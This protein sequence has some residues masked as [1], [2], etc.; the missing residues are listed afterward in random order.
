[1]SASSNAAPR[2]PRSPSRHHR[3]GKR[4]AAISRPVPRDRPAGGR[5]F[6]QIATH[7]PPVGPRTA[8]PGRPRRGCRPSHSPR[9]TRYDGAP[10]PRARAPS[11]HRVGRRREVE[12]PRRPPSGQTSPV[13][14]GI[15]SS[16]TRCPRRSAPGGGRGP[17]RAH[18]HHTSCSRRSQRCAAAR[19]RPRRHRRDARAR[20]MQR[21]TVTSSQAS[22]PAHAGGTR[23]HHRGAFSAARWTSLAPRPDWRRPPWRSPSPRRC[24]AGRARATA[25]PAS[26]PGASLAAS[27]EHRGRRPIGRRRPIHRAEPRR[28][29]V[30]TAG[31][32]LG[33]AEQLHRS[34]RRG[35]RVRRDYQCGRR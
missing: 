16:A 5:R 13:T 7:R 25:P 22:R 32:H 3:H 21:S 1:M 30:V 20:L 26:R 24:P 14:S 33:G 19:G 15:A 8:A 4:E 23:G 34:L 28:P 31:V 11:P 10:R 18:G 12:A 27:D 6:A 29:R 17:H 9:P 35:A 2:R